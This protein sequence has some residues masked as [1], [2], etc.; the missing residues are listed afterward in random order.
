MTL[1]FSWQ[2]KQHLTK[3]FT[4]NVHLLTQPAG[5]AGSTVSTAHRAVN[6]IRAPGSSFCWSLSSHHCRARGAQWHQWID[7]RYP[8]QEMMWA[9]R[10]LSLGT[11]TPGLPIC[12]APSAFTPLG[13][14]TDR[15]SQGWAGLELVLA[16]HSLAAQLECSAFLLLTL[17]M[18]AKW[19]G[20]SVVSV[21]VCITITFILKK[22]F[23]LNSRLQENNVCSSGIWV[24]LPVPRWEYAVLHVV[25][26]R[27]SLHCLLQDKP[28]GFSRP[29][30]DV[31]EWR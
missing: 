12:S 23:Y 13:W 4:I 17:Q 5:G 1:S 10:C 19:F 31:K 3:M 16:P 2:F 7:P 20:R 6:E 30:L 24:S 25:Y 29:M 8:A 11:T 9:I 27:C 14:Q 26:A 28:A 18:S 21:C 22:K 15:S